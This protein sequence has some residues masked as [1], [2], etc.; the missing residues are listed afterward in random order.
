MPVTLLTFIAF[1]CQS[2]EREEADRP[3]VSHLSSDNGS[4]GNGSWGNGSWG[5]G[6]WG[7]GSWGN[8]TWGNGSWGN[9]TWGNGSWGNGTWGNGTWGNGTWGN[10]TWGNGTWGNGTWGN[11][12]WGNGTW[13]NGT[14]GNGTWGNGMLFGTLSV[15]DLDISSLVDASLVGEACD[16]SPNTS[17]SMTELM[18]YVAA[19]QCALPAPCAEND[20][21]CMSQIDCGSNS[22]CRT[23]TDCQGNELYVAGRHGLGT[24]QGDPAIVAA[25]DACIDATL[26]ELN[27]DFRAYADNLNNYAASCALPE[28]SGGS[29][30]SDPGCIEVTYQLYPSGTETK[31]YY[32]GIGLS[33]SWKNNPDFDQDPEGQRRVSACLA[34]R[35]NPH[36][37]KV[38]LSIRGMGI[39]TTSTELATYGHH[40]GAFW[41]N[42]FDANPLVYSCSVNG[43]GPS[44]RICTGGQCSFIDAGP[45]DIA[46]AQ[47]DVDGNYTECGTESSTNVINTFLPLEN[48]IASG[49]RHTCIRKADGTVWCWG[50][51]AEYQ[52]GDGTKVD[53]LDAVQVPGI[54]DTQQV[55]AT[56]YNSCVTLKDGSLKC[57]G[58]GSSGVLGHGSTSWSSV[59]VQ[60]LGYVGANAAQINGLFH[61]CGIATDGS[62]WC[63][64]TNDFG[65]LGDG[66]M[67]N[68]HAPVQVLGLQGVVKVSMGR[69]H[70]C[71]LQ[72][73]SEV[74]CWGK[75]DY[76]A[77]GQGVLADQTSTALVVSLPETT[78]DISLGY[79][80]SCA[81]SD[82]GNIWCWG[83]NDYGQ[84]G[85]GTLQDQAVPTMTQGLPAPARAVATADNHACALLEDDTVWCWGHNSLGQLG[86]G[87]MSY[88]S[89]VPVYAQNNVSEIT[90]GEN[91]TCAFSNDGAAYCWGE[92]GFGQLGDGTIQ[93]RG[94]PTR[95]DRF[96]D[97]GD[98][99]CDFGETVSEQ[100]IDCDANWT[101]QPAKAVCSSNV[102]CCSGHCK[103]NGQCK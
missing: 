19:I 70:S 24:N 81:L 69:N 6:S 83:R 25:V 59:P 58:R 45:C 88:R 41:G 94:A 7:N 91:F 40:E 35:T 51:N 34:A 14:W 95:V 86:D 17:A 31:Q 8:G 74:H 61:M 15:G 101:C 4:W 37:K 39:P 13:G 5:N 10:G 26:E 29:C 55:M 43:G 76:G 36:R 92:N 44:G 18:V 87:T 60:P 56:P 42:M 1:G 57:W 20:E 96:I 100:P 62:L 79:F 28:S 68:Q 82:V 102:E 66:T 75:S 73:G 97:H 80:F 52:L 46:C 33:P 99:V 27:A 16:P 64:G 3:A 98:G 38:Q 30:S 63:W 23:L 77:L 48:N 93:N 90:T 103:G 53:S 12:T 9:G 21:V 49:W 50:Y 84:L 11:G 71:S 65:Q 85:D 78:V 22:D 54:E 2:T 89:T 72:I 67:E 47:Q 32:G